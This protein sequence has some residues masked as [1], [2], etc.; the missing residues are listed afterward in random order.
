M[1]SLAISG[2]DWLEVPTI[3]KA[4][5][6]PK[7]QGI[8]WNMAQNMVLP[9][10]H[11][12]IPE[13]PHWCHGCFMIK[14]PQWKLGRS[15]DSSPSHHP[16]NKWYGY[17]FGM[18]DVWHCFYPPFFSDSLYI[19]MGWPCVIS[20]RMTSLARQVLKTPLP[21]VLWA[22][23]HRLVPWRGSDQ[24]VVFSSEYQLWDIMGYIA[25]LL[26][27]LGLFENRVY[28]P[29]PDTWDM[30]SHNGTWTI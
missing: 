28:S 6:R 21:L 25:C 16:F 12:R 19:G 5:I 10:L 17:H 15:R 29:T 23:G 7:F 18:G 13:I 8:S 20:S 2:T 26:W 14:S 3:Y 1:S 30:M 27:Y 9:Y 4:Y 24:P 22:T 11:F